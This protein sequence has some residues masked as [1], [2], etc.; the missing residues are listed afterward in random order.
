[1]FL[2]QHSEFEQVEFTAF[3]SDKKFVENVLL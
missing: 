3:L 1:M 2:E